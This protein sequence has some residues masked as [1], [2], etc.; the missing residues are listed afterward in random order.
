MF[1]GGGI[2]IWFIVK[3]RDDDDELEIR[4]REVLVVVAVM[5]LF[6]PRSRPSDDCNVASTARNS[7][8][9]D[10]TAVSAPSTCFS[11]LSRRPRHST[12]AYLLSAGL[13]EVLTGC[14][15]V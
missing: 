1:F 5:L 3:T 9:A 15:D 2:G 8:F 14:A 7:F 6:F 10:A 13:L 11:A 4:R 12:R